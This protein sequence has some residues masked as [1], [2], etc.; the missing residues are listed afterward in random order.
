MV[1]KRL[2]SV[3]KNTGLSEMTKAELLELIANGESSQVE[4]KRKFNRNIDLA[5]ELVAF[6]N[7]LGGTLII[8][9]DDDGTISGVDDDPISM[10][11][12]V[13]TACRDKIMPPL[14]PSYGTVK[15]VNGDKT[16]VI[17]KV[18]S[19]YCVHS[20]WHN[21][22]HRYLIRVGTQ[23]REAS[24]DELIRLFQQRGS[25]SAELQPISGTS[26][27]D[28]NMRRLNN[29]FSDIRQQDIPPI[30]NQGE[31]ETL[32]R[33]TEIM[34]ENGVTVGGMLLFGN[35]PKKFLHQSGIDA[36]AFKGTEK[37]YDTQERSMLKGPLTPLL[38]GNGSSNFDKKSIV[39]MGLV[40]Q[41]LAFVKRNTHPTVVENGGMRREQQ[42]YPDDVLREGIEN[43]II[44]RDYL[45]SGTTIELSIYS[46]RL[47]IIS[48]GKLPNGITIDGVR[49]GAR[50]S[51]NELINNVLRDYR[52]VEHMGMGIPKK[53]IKGMLNYNGTDPEFIETNERFIVKLMA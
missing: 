4:F 19:G 47:E 20:L 27:A 26:I 24:H 45:L 2:F 39:E 22:S 44:H 25:V 11:E 34:T 14:I 49:A 3:K 43:A 30:D 35:N 50:A 1:K 10:E 32:L 6:S 12:W 41:A 17:I 29:Y 48:P 21:G 51:R 37:D 18:L 23:S 5:K 53:I 31:W 13:M 52:Y 15:N 33:N 36:F 7:L 40:E 46:D 42:T 28:L 9:V 16:V 8:G 38:S